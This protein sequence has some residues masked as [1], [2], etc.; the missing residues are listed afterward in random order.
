MV[1]DEFAF[2]VSPLGTDLSPSRRLTNG[3][4]SE[5]TELIDPTCPIGKAALR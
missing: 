3:T 5:L 2:C 1:S 4:R